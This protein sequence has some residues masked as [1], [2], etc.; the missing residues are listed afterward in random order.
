MTAINFTQQGALTHQFGV[1]RVVTAKPFV[2][3]VAAHC[4]AATT[5]IGIFSPWL[6]MESIV[7]CRPSFLSYNRHTIVMSQGGSH[8]E[9]RHLCRN[10]PRRR[11]RRVDYDPMAAS[12]AFSV[13]GFQGITCGGGNTENCRNSTSLKY[14]LNVG[15]FR[16]AA[17][18]QF[19][20]YGQNNASNGAY[21]FGAGADI[22]NLGNGVLSLDAIYSY[23]RDAV[24]LGLAPGSND[25]NG[26]PIPPF[27]PQ[28]LTATI[29]DNRAVMAL[30]KYANGPLKLYAGYEQ[31]RFMAP[32][33][34]QS[35]F[36]DIAGTFLCL[37][38][39]AFNNTNINNAAFGVNGLGDRILH[40]MWTGV[41]YAV[42]NELDV[43]AAYTI[44]SR[45][46]SSAPLPGRR[47]VPA[48][49]ARN[50]PV[51]WTRTLLLSIGSLHR[52]GISISG[53]CS[54]KRMADWLTAFSSATTS[55]PRSD[56]AS[57]A[58]AS[59]LRPIRASA[60]RRIRPIH[61]A[62]RPPVR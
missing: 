21:Q 17:L 40:V 18:W 34:P 15:Q 27:L 41:K 56:C 38:C 58:E 22:A 11:W 3:T 30:A 59:R 16:V 7:A 12:N 20:G 39:V 54:R 33:D 43:I 8:D 24:S 1:K 44:T 10:D 19:G 55:I 28:T 49:R 57:A 5:W 52:S 42:T 46:P 47:H 36:T 50:A 14:R 45:I 31:I 2:I 6:H 48:A 26:V 32:S 9:A 35:A 60:L 37:G 61:E 53:S 62:T 13:I 23:V 25:A 4:S 51:R 29:S